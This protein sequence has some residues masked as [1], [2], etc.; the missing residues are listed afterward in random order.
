MCN[1]L[2]NDTSQKTEISSSPPWDSQVLQMDSNL[3]FIALLAS[4]D[5]TRDNFQVLISIYSDTDLS[6][7]FLPF[8][9]HVYINNL[10]HVREVVNHITTMLILSY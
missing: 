6:N 5:L 7:S 2:Q 9:L 8:S 4:K 3:I 10:F 1:E